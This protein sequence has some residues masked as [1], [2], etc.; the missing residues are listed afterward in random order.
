[1][2]LRKAR[3]PIRIRAENGQETL[4]GRGDDMKALLYS[5]AIGLLAA[6]S[7]EAQSVQ[8]QGVYQIT[9]ET[10]NCPFDD[11]GTVG[12]AR[13]RPPLPENGPGASLTLFIG[14]QYVE[15]Y[16]TA[17]DFTDNFQRVKGR[18]IGGAFGT[19]NDVRVK[20][21]S[22]EPAEITADTPFVQVAG[23]IRGF[24]DRPDCVST[25]RMVAAK[26]S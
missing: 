5:L 17:E 16:A 26:R 7:A 19:M 25:F 18:N 11:V 10:G 6:G 2:A 20:F 8:W 12:I 24:D 15:N 23:K 9:A 14:R 1:M 4:L 21:D 22:V 13:F 3:H